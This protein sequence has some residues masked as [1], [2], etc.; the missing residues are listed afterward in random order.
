MNPPFPP[1]RLHLNGFNLFPIQNI[2]KY[3]KICTDKS[4]FSGEKAESNTQ[5]IALHLSLSIIK[6]FQ[7]LFWNEISSVYRKRINL[8]THI[9]HH[10]VSIWTVST[11]FLYK[12]SK[13]TQK[14]AL[15]KVRFL[16][17]VY[18]VT[19]RESHY[20][21]LYQLLR[22]FNPYFETKYR[23]CIEK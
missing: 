22:G 7:T 2:K 20:T 14:Y 16:G 17:K 19:P 21:F 6:R 9:F 23:R 3:S 8:W 13:N 11:F 15:I 12:I 18:K 10:F 5:G 1:F 4:A